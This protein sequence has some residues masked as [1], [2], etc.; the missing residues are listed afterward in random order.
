MRIVVTGG[1]GFIASHV[2]DAYLDLGHEVHVLD[3]FSTGSRSNLN[4]RAVAHVVD[5]ADP[6]AAQLIREIR[7]EVLNH[8]AAQMDVRR[9]VSDPVFD[10]RV[11]VLG[12]VNLLEPCRDVG[13]RKV[14]FSSSGGAVYGD[15]EPIPAPEDR[16]TLPLSPYGVSKLS[17]EYYL[18]YYAAVFGLPYVALRYANVYGPRQSSRGE[19]GVVAIFISRLL[20]GLQPVINGDGRQT[21]DYVYVDDVVRANIAA[22]ETAHVGPVNIGTGTETDVVT[23]FRL[24]RAGL[25]TRIDA[26]H[27]PAKPGEQRRSCLDVTRARDVLGWR[28]SVELEEG[29]RKTIAYYRERVLD[30]A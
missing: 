23:L 26:I 24:V 15:G 8:H 11:N 4:P 21:R 7:P 18:A 16:P 13:T 28:P 1:A 20:A 9:S 17:G 5:I 25:G 3:D 14:I 10:A 30:G 19:A 22:L 12:L 29:L 2:V 27:G 6:A